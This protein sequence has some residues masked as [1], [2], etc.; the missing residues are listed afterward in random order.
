MWARVK[1]QTENGLL[2]LP[3]KAYMFRPGFMQPLY[4]I[5]SKTSW[6]RALYAITRP[7]YPLLKALFPKYMITTQ[8]LGRAMISVAKHGAPTQVLEVE[9]IRRCCAT[10]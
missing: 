1:G 3:F 2:R 5:K 10:S 6:Y 8:Q 4:G 9:D 7:V